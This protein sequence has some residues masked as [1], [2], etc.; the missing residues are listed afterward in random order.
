MTNKL[1]LELIWWIFTALVVVGFL[2]PIYTTTNMY[3]YR[4]LNILFIVAFITLT[5]YIF[6][7][8]VTWLS[9]Q[10][11]VKVV[12]IFCSPVL[13]FLLVQEVNSF[14]TFIDEYG[15]EVIIGN[16]PVPTLASLSKYIH[17]ELLFF[18]VGSV[19]SAFLL[20][21]RLI[22]SIWRVRNLGKE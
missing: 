13:V 2:F 4:N 11:V 1:I 22:V 5:R 19:I 8:P 10:E 3:Y 20:P 21:I 9:Y 18:G 16:L 17:A 14:Q 15:W 6:L 12:L 7:L